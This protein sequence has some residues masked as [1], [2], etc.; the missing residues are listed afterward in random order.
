M[1]PVVTLSVYAITLFLGAGLL[2]VVQPMVGK[3]ILPFAGG[4]PA[5]W[6]TCLV[7][8]QSALLAGYAYAHAT[9]TWLGTRRQALVHLAVLALPFFVLPLGINRGFLRGGDASPILDVL[10]VLVLSVGVPFVVVSATA[11]LLQAWF[12]GTRHP[13]ARDPYF[14]YAA[15][16]LGSMLA[17]LSYP[18]LVE[19]RLP[20]AGAGW[21]TQ[22]RL[23]T[24]GYGLLAALTALCALISR[25]DASAP[26]SVSSESGS[27]RR[28]RRRP[29]PPTSARGSAGCTGWR[30]PSCPPACCWAPRPTS[31]PTSRPS[32][33]CGSLPLALY[34]LSFI[35]AFGR[36]P[37]WAHRVVTAA[38]LPVVLV[39]LFLILSDARHRIWVTVL[40]HLLALFVV[41]LAVH[42]ELARLRPSARSV[43]EFYL[44]ISV[45]AP[46]E[47]SSTRS[48]PRSSS[49]R[50][51]NIRSPWRSPASWCDRPARRRRSRASGGWIS[52]F[53]LPW[54]RSS[55]CSSPRP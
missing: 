43:T 18:L 33:C 19:P 31:R 45:G 27:G 4:T 32:R 26:V 30:S 5:V 52:G 17:L 3:M 47:V 25:I 10:A 42:G 24:L 34:L 8:F 14:L 36:W 9:T 7:F 44:L 23:W 29:R 2:F 22:T 48:S 50:S 1:P 55:S 38:M 21:L 41:S 20:L 16:N 12:A 6:S 37:A 39:G 28:A 53:R 13:A 54:A 11:P 51:W 35:L 49:A 46:S 40:W 15:S